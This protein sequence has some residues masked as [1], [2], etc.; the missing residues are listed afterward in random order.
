[1]VSMTGEVKH[2]CTI[3]IDFLNEIFLRI[4]FYEILLSRISSGLAI[5]LQNDM[6]FLGY[7]ACT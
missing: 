4:I 7:I 5:Y 6:N 1:M 2:V 3:N